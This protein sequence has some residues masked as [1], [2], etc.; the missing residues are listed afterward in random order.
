M[1]ETPSRSMSILMSKDDNFDSEARQCYKNNSLRAPCRH[2]GWILS[3]QICIPT[4][5]HQIFTK[6]IFCEFSYGVDIPDLVFQGLCFYF[7]IK[8]TSLVNSGGDGGAICS[9][10]FCTIRMSECLFVSE[11]FVG[12]RVFS[13]SLLHDRG[14]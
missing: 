10:K 2:S 4:P 14:R 6:S 11:V 12:Q 7:P 5:N 8:K 1:Q 3:R 13:I 9:N